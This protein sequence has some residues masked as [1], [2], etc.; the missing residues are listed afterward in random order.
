MISG[1]CSRTF[2]CRKMEKIPPVP[3]FPPILMPLKPTPSSDRV[4]VEE[5]SEALDQRTGSDLRS[6]RDL[7]RHSS[8]MERAHLRH[9]PPYARRS[10]GRREP[11]HQ[12]QAVPAAALP[13]SKRWSS[14]IQNRSSLEPLRVLRRHRPPPARRPPPSNSEA[15]TE[16]KS[17]HGRALP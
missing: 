4:P 8:S 14:Y 17:G 16:V 1:G 11:Y 5:G 13:L 15:P 9:R 6:V 10:P 3:G 7:E 12:S 2:D